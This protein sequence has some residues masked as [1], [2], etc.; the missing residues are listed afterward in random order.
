MRRGRPLPR[1]G[2]LTFRTPARHRAPNQEPGKEPD[3]RRRTSR[4]SGGSEQACLPGD[5]GYATPAACPVSTT[6]W[7]YGLRRTCR[8][9]A[10]RSHRPRSTWPN[11]AR[12]PLPRSRTA[13]SGYIVFGSNNFRSPTLR[14]VAV[15]GAGGRRTADRPVMRARLGWL[16]DVSWRV[17]PSGAFPAGQC[18]APHEHHSWHRGQASR[19]GAAVMA[20]SPG[21]GWTRWPLAVPKPGSVPAIGPGY[22]LVSAGSWA[23]TWLPSSR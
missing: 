20:G 3:P 11:R 23:G 16:L 14:S 21:P 15:H 13:T 2:E 7:R 19:A 8:L 22:R 5:G 9:V 12:L 4:G 10:G 1:C 18:P 17:G 6:S